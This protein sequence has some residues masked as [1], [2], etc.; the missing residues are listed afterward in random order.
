MPPRNPLAQGDGTACCLLVVEFDVH[1]LGRELVVRHGGLYQVMNI[2]T[3]LRCR[4]ED[5]ICK[6]INLGIAGSLPVHQAHDHS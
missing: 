1:A 4:N 6:V 2:A 3:V 5:T